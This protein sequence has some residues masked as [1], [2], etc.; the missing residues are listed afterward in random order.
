MSDWRL[1]LWTY[2][3]PT[4]SNPTRFVGNVWSIPWCPHENES[5]W[6]THAFA[7]IQTTV[8]RNFIFSVC[9]FCWRCI[10]NKEYMFG[11]A[12]RMQPHM[13]L[14]IAYW[15]CDGWSLITW[16]FFLDIIQSST[17]DFSRNDNR[18]STFLITYLSTSVSEATRKHHDIFLT[19][20]L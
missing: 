11:I 17:A 16:N 18:E 10:N 9:P 4:Y 20:E 7:F 15:E 8:F 19:I 1:C 6:H 13:P 5:C 12:P 14:V 3:L 2:T